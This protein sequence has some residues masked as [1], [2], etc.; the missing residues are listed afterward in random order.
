MNVRQHI[1]LLGKR[2]EDRVTGFRGVISSVSFDLYGCV[3]AVL[4]PGIDKEGKPQESHWFDVSRLKVSTKLRVM[5]P[6]QF[7]FDPIG[8][9]EKPAN[10][11]P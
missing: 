5:T 1:E 8:P 4:N 11:K 3:Q 7:E 6:P 2:A 9:A 10:L